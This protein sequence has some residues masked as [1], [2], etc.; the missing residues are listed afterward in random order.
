MPESPADAVASTTSSGF[1][2]EDR[3]F[4]GM[5]IEEAR[6]SVAEDSRPHPM[7]GVVVVKDGQVLSTGYRG[8]S[9][10]G[11][12]AEYVA[13]EKKLNTVSVAGA[14]VYTTLE[15]CTTRNHP[16]IPCAE[17][18]CERRV[19]RVVI[20]MLDPNP[21]ITGRGLQTL[22][23]SR[24]ATVLFT[25]DLMEQVEELNREF[26][27]TFLR[28]TDAE[29]PPP[30]VVS[31]T[32]VDHGAPRQMR[33]LSYCRDVES[34]LQLRDGAE[35]DASLIGLLTGA[36]SSGGIRF[37][38]LR[39]V[40]GVVQLI[41]ERNDFS[42]GDWAL[43]AGLKVG[44]RVS[45]SGRVGK[46][47]SGEA[48][49]F[50]YRVPRVHDSTLEG[51]IAGA[52]PDYARVGH[53]IFVARLCN[54][55]AEFLRGLNYLEIE[56][57]F[58]SL[59]WPSRGVEPLELV[60]PGFGGSAYLV[61]TP[62]T[63][64]IEALVGT[65]TKAVFA[66][67]RCF[68]TTFRDEKASVESLIVS[69]KAIDVAPAE[70]YDLLRRCVWYSFGELETLPN[71]GLFPLQEWRRIV[72]DGPLSNHTGSDVRVPT[73]EVYRSPGIARTEGGVRVLELCRFVW[74]PRRTIA[75]GAQEQLDSGLTLASTTM[76]IERM[77]S[78]LRDVPVRQIQNLGIG[79]TAQ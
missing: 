37:F 20:G 72:I 36:R 51:P 43:L 18:I 41:A 24:I 57:N 73:L 65:G 21:Q 47:K 38:N 14:T 64:L 52:A 45:A 60:Y 75:E 62:A 66:K 59:E 4:A 11:N 17:R 12:H 74:P 54:R 69:A 31:A 25:S 33:R 1:T 30:V 10:S 3:R 13:L 55:V 2:A 68:S 15:P 8:E 26:A 58:I 42:E 19:A 7:V 71:A 78:L 28:A 5:A 32:M 61:P 79:G 49:I 63:Q 39:D 9:A 50:L 34:H 77:A 53:K 46:S 16:K 67:S 27:R 6:K 56:P 29:Q 22:R 70:H 44:M 48:S 35:A 23:S 76:H 40:T